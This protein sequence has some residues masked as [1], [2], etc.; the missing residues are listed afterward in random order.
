MLK[1]FIFSDKRKTFIVGNVPDDIDLTAYGVRMR[2]KLMS[3]CESRKCT[4]T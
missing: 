1:T 3:I 2:L 4:K